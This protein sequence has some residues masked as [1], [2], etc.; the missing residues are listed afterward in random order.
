MMAI[1]TLSEF[2][3]ETSNVKDGWFICMLTDELLI[4]K[5]DNISS[6]SLE[7]KEEKILE[8]RGFNSEKELKLFRSDIGRRFIFREIN[9][10]E[11]AENI[12]IISEIQI[13]DVDATIPKETKGIMGN[14]VTATGGGKYNLPLANVKNSKL[15]I[16]YYV[17]SKRDSDTNMMLSGQARVVDW[18]VVELM[19][20]ENG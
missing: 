15:K 10:S 13:I 2:L 16:N 14:V 17:T 7:A 8:I 9:D 4:D 6:Y 20:G 18:R 3:D 11:L 5:I 1:E 12:E 19:E